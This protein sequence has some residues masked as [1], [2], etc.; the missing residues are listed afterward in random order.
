MTEFSISLL[1]NYC[2][3]IQ[4]CLQGIYNII[5]AL[6]LVFAFLMFFVGAFKNFLSTIPDIKMEGK[7][8]MRNA[9]IGLVAIFVSGIFLQWINPEIFNA[10]LVIYRV[11]LSLPQI[12]ITD[13]KI[14]KSTIR[15]GRATPFSFRNR[16]ARCDKFL[17]AID[18]LVDIGVGANGLYDLTK[19]YLEGQRLNKEQ[20]KVLLKALLISESGGDNCNPSEFQNP[21]SDYAFATFGIEYIS[22]PISTTRGDKAAYQLIVKEAQEIYNSLKQYV[23]KKGVSIDIGNLKQSDF[24]INE[25]RVGGKLDNPYLITTVAIKRLSTYQYDLETE[26]QSFKLPPEYSKDLILV[27]LR[28]KAGNRGLQ[29][30]IKTRSISHFDVAQIITTIKKGTAGV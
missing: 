19:Y 5:V 27:L 22:K 1:K 20:V 12:L 13:T 30:Y 11:N 15:S 9:I 26:L 16:G 7:R 21:R 28:Y 23:A 14:V 18:E 25:L 4:G 6:A 8:Q 24:N 3:N 10:Q 2:T 29:E 17:S